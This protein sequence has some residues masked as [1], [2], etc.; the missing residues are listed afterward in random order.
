MSRDG[1]DALAVV[2]NDTDV[3]Y[4]VR[5]WI[6]YRANNQNRVK[7]LHDIRLMDGSVHL[8]YYPNARAWSKFV[9]GSG[10]LR[11]S[12]DEVEAIRLSVRQIGDI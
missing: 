2:L 9:E 4:Y 7:L 11:V 12:D 3:S 10:P 1:R 5:Q 6:D 8:G